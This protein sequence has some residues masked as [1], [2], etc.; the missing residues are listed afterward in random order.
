[1][2]N[3][4]EAIGLNPWIGVLAIALLIVAFVLLGGAYS[5]ERAMRFEEDLKDIDRRKP[6]ARKRR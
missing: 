3:P 5:Q 1:M 4:F 2:N 6:H